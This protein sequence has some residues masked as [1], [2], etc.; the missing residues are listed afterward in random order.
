MAHRRVRKGKKPRKAK[1]LIV[2]KKFR[3]A[4]IH[5]SKLS[6][7]AQRAAVAQIHSNFIKDLSSVL[8]KLRKR[9]DLVTPS[10][11][12]HIFKNKNK[13]RKLVNPKTSIKKKREILIQRGG[14]LPALLVYLVASAASGGLKLLHA[15][16]VL[17]TERAKKSLSSKRKV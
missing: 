8:K 15:Q 4:I 6:S 17:S 10:Q 16:H 2:K 5:L 14:I 13:L 12:K 9:A 7:N 11:R 1:K 3:K